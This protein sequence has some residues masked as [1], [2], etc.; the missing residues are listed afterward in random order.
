M[1]RKLVENQQPRLPLLPASPGQVLPSQLPPLG[2]TERL[3]QSL[4]GL[5]SNHQPRYTDLHLKERPKHNLRRHEQ[6]PSRHIIS[7]K[8]TAVLPPSITATS[9]RVVPRERRQSV[10]AKEEAAQ[11]LVLKPPTSPP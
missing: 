7:P 9:P 11:P 5:K 3:I 2:P 1:F 10:I 6:R 4:E 8:A